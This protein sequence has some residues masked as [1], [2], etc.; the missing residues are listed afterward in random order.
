MVRSRRGFNLLE[1]LIASAIL[2]ITMMILVD[3]QG[4]AAGMVRR[5]QEIE[6]GTVLAQEKM[7]EVLLMAEQMGIGTDDVREDGD[8]DDFGA[9]LEIEWGDA[10]DSYRWEYSIEEIELSLAPDIAELAGGM[11]GFMDDEAAGA[12]SSEAGVS[13]EDFGVSNDM[14]TEQLSRFIRIVRVKVWWGKQPGANASDAEKR[15]AEARTVEITTHIVNPTGAY[16]SGTLGG[17]SES[18]TPGAGSFAPGSFGGL[19]G[20]Q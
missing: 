19:R 5:A 18:G 11:G 3:I 8:F 17:D 7:A 20:A 14:I 4:R 13:L 1:V 15:L 9:D 16:G 6:V 2:L 12:A 10:L